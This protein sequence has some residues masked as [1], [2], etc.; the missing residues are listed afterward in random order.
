MPE[1][2]GGCVNIYTHLVLCELGVQR[3]EKMLLSPS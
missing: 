3:G 2:E 1:A